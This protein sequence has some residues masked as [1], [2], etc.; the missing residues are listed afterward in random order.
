MTIRTRVLPALV[1]LISSAVF[2]LAWAAQPPRPPHP[3]HPSHPQSLDGLKAAAKVVRDVD[4]IAHVQA[5]NEHDLFFLQGYI[6]AQDRLFQMDV[7]RR[8]ADGTLAELLG[9]GALPNDVQLRTIGLERSGERTY[10]ALLADAAAGDRTS[11]SVLAAMRAYAEGVNAFLDHATVLPPEYSALELTQVRPWQVTDSINV[12]KLIAFGLS[13]DLEDISNSQRL[14]AFQSVLG[15][16]A[17]AALFFEDLFR[18]QPFNPASTVPDSGGNGAR[19][20]GNKPHA[21]STRRAM[22]A[23]P[24]ID[25]AVRELSRRYLDQLEYAPTM[26]T[27]V[28]N[29]RSARGSNNWGVAGSRT[30]SGHPIIANDP[31]LT[32]DHPTT[33]YP[34]HLSAP[35]Y[36]VIGSGFAGVPFVIVGHNPFIAW[37]PTTN[38]LDVTDVYLEQL[39]PDAS[40]PSGLS[41]LFQGQP[42]HVIPIA[43]QWFANV[44]GDGIPDNQVLANHAV[45]LIVPRRNNGPIVQSLASGQALSVQFTGFSATRE[46]ESFYLWNK[47]RD[48]RDFRNGLRHFDFGSQNWAYADKAGNL[49][50]FTSGEMPVRADL[51]AGDAS[52]PPYFIRNG[53]SGAFEWLPVQHPQPGQVLPYEIYPESAMPSVINPRNGWFVNANNDPAGTSLDNN[54]LNDSH[55]DVPGIYYLNQGYASGFRAGRI[56]TRLQRL[57]ATG[58]GKVTAQDMADIQADVG[59]LDAEYFVPQLQQAFADAQ[60]PGAD[61][62]LAAAAA[63]P[64]LIEALQRFGDWADLDFQAKT[65]ILEG[66]DSEDD[67][68]DPT[69]S[70]NPS[71]VT[72]SAATT[73]YS[74]WRSSFTRNT[75]LATLNANGLGA[76]APGSALQMTSLRNLLEHDGVSASGVKFFAGGDGRA[77]VQSV[78]LA[79][80][81]DALNRLASPEFAA[82]FGGSTEQSAYRWG[83]LHRIVFD[84]PLG[85]PFSVP[86]A[87][88]GFPAPL[89]GL[90]GIPT[91]GGFSTVDASSHSTSATGV[92]GF[93]FGSGPT[94]RMVVELP[95]SGPRARS[96]WPGGTSAVPGEPFYVLPM[97]PRWL[98]NDANPLRFR[99]GE[100]KAGEFSEQVFVP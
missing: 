26:K 83:M 35:D 13:F 48:L 6:H 87:F 27:I 18:S 30:V 66:F 67:D 97:L 75:L 34:M 15:A 17:G 94:N 71:E 38:P 36:D 5:R 100:I 70:F 85:P 93:M 21:A 96:V 3:Q 4:G 74:V 37:G 84:S 42:E 31:H 92:N 14:G 47:A 60:A 82:A 63:D 12:G 72:A 2:S 50:Y 10:Q 91:D 98:T 79:S 51:A 80:L 49:A 69:G 58:N 32:L 46:L 76:L 88:D 22:G 40:S 24:H 20:H 99:S 29:D 25:D 54:P 53:Q 33:F 95:R 23:V 52:S 56:T 16:Q 90:P 43:Q 64:R 39:V 19:P 73:L 61:P 55:P 89:P 78:L 59:L 11:I 57:F 28:E 65:G 41:T 68:G 7:S 45:T 9:P 86:P 77:K 1:L 8:T 81:S 44:V 62:A